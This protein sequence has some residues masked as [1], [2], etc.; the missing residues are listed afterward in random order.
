MLEIDEMMDTVNLFYTR[1]K[2]PKGLGDA[3]Y[4]AKS[5]V[6]QEPFALLLGDTI[7]IP[8]CTRELITK[9]EEFKASIVAVEEVPREKIRS[10]GIV[11][12]REVEDG[13]LL[14]EDMIEKPSPETAP[15]NL[16]ILGRYIL[17][18]AIFDALD[19]TSPGI[20]NEIQLTDA[21]RNLDE[22]KYAYIY[23]G[24]RY[25]IGNKFD[26]I[27]SNIEL[28]LQDERFYGEFNRFLQSLQWNKNEQERS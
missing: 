14:I 3:I 5:F 28:F 26:W 20:A 16:G 6:G 12:G 8:R 17:T 13:I 1:Q 25:D 27:K 7:T 24:R 9:Y 21:L 23:R 10:Y 4:Y 22:K 18:P 15:S 19:R 11:Q 2:E